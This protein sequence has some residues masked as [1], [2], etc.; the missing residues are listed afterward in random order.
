MPLPSKYKSEKEKPILSLTKGTIYCTVMENWQ[1]SIF[2]TNITKGLECF[3]NITQG[4]NMEYEFKLLSS[5]EKVFF[6]KLED[7]P[8]HTSGSTF[9]NESNCSG[10]R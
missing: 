7:L 3:R 6:D 4:K 10:P 2:Q 5:L 9:K 8:E 1:R